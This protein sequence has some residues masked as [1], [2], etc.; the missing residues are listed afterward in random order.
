MA[1]TRTRDIAENSIEPPNRTNQGLMAACAR[2]L[3]TYP[4]GHPLPMDHPLYL[5]FGQLSQD[6]ARLAA[7][8][9][10]AVLGLAI[11]WGVRRPWH[12]RDPRFPHEWAVGCI[13]TALISP[14]CWRQHLVVALPAAFLLWRAVLAA[15][16]KSAL[17]WQAIVLMLLVLVPQREILG[18]ALTDVLLSYKLDTL[19]LLGYTA[20]LFR[21]A[22]VAAVAPP[23]EVPDATLKQP[24]AAQQ[25]RAA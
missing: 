22:P 15:P 11:A 7:Q 14:L 20:L 24:I 17:R 19:A 3:Q 9:I 5:Q 18:R 12:V 13:F 10:F 6:A 8:G 4:A 2:Y 16:Q 25:P 1:A 21:I 23:V